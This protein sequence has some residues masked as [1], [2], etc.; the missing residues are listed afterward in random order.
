MTF[1]QNP[2]ADLPATKEE[3]EAARR[4]L[5][6]YHAGCADGFCAAWVYW[7]QNPTA[8]FIP[9]QYG[10]DPPPQAFQGRDVLIFDFSYR[11]HVLLAIK[12]RAKSV[13]VLDHHKTAKAELESLDFC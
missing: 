7:R 9:V 12:E 11:R 3:Y 1:D 4:P 10:E 6:L 8:E 2:V 13:L 5:V